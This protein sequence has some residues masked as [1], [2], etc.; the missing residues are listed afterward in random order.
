MLTDTFIRQVKYKGAGKHGDTYA[1][2]GSLFLVVT[3]TGSKLWRMPYRYLDKQK[4]LAIGVYPAVKAAQ[5]RKVRDEARELLAKGIDPSEAKRAQKTAQKAAAANSV[6][7]VGRAYLELKQN[8]WSQTH[9]D[10]ETRNLVRDVF[11]FLGLRAIGEVEPPDLLAVIRKVEDRG[12]LVTAHRVLYT[13]RGVWQYAVAN[14]LAKRDITQDIA[15]ALKTPTKDHYPALTTQTE[16]GELLRAA[17]AYQGGPVVRTA[18][19]IAPVLFQRPGNLRTMRWAQ[20][21]LDAARWTIPS[22]ELK[23]RK[24]QKRNGP[25][26]VVP[27]PTQVVE[28]LRELQPLTGF[29]EYVFPGHRDPR[30]PMSEG[31]LSA[32]LGS[33]GYK[34]RHTWHGYRATGRTLIREVLGC[35]IDVIESQMAHVSH[36]SHGGAYDRAK[37]IDARV[38]MLQDWADYL[39][40]LRTGA[41]VIPLHRSA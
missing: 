18:F 12:R 25:P 13:A 1:D 30:K 28:A 32:A 9:T 23:R 16:L 31:A 10:R 20:V 38:K 26:H 8:D 35:D 5:A 4:K 11:P 33:L 19:R 22:E 21:D 24:E 3:P 7:A 6:E 37:F 39:D 36:I 17:D 27:L 15:R 29:R 40:K 34:G 2:G 41:D 14:G